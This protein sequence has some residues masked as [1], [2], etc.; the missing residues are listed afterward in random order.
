LE[1][2]N[3]ALSSMLLK[4][5]INKLHKLRN[6]GIASLIK[7]LSN[8]NYLYEVEK[9]EFFALA[10]KNEIARLAKS[11]MGK[12]FKEKCALTEEMQR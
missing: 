12:L 2:D 11:L 10:N 1:K 9:D 4:E 5:I 3:S 6:K 7:Y 8:V